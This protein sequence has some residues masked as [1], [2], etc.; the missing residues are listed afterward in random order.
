M[1]SDGLANES[2]CRKERATTET[3]PSAGICLGTTQGQ[4]E[5][6]NAASGPCPAHGRR[7]ND[8]LRVHGRG[9]IVSVSLSIAAAGEKAIICA[10]LAVAQTAIDGSDDGS[11]GTAVAKIGNVH[12]AITSA[13]A[14]PVTMTVWL[15][16]EVDSLGSG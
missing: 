12:W 13:T 16:G 5:V 10:L 11:A 15:A 9:G 14:G 1:G 3:S 7:L 2:L 6:K 8:E 4:A